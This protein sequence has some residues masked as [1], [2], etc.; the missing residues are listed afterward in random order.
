MNQL[1]RACSLSLGFALAITACDGPAV[2]DAPAGGQSIE[3]I[4]AALTGA[5]T[6]IDAHFNTGTLDD[7]FVFVKDPFRG[8][9]APAYELG[10]VSP[11]NG[12]NGTGTIEVVLGGLDDADILGMSGGW[13]KSFTLAA[14]A[15]VTVTFR[16]NLL[17]SANYESDEYADANLSLDATLVGPN[18]ATRLARISGDGEGGPVR[19]TGWQQITLN[20]GSVAAGTHTLTFGGFNNKKTDSSEIS[21]VNIDDVLVTAF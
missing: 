4:S 10:A 13:R 16:F 8:T 18:G 7:G 17:Q 19:S 9:H 15:S 21:E 2:L 6:L 12:F 14:A 20:L 5:S 1:T 3:S 11:S